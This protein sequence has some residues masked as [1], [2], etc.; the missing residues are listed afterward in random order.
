[1][2]DNPDNG[3]THSSAVTSGTKDGLG[4]IIVCPN[5]RAKVSPSPVEPVRGYDLP[6]VAMI[7]LRADMHSPDDNMIILFDEKA[8]SVAEACSRI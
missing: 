6:P 5:V 4:G 8:I 3:L 2:R 1:M 7:T